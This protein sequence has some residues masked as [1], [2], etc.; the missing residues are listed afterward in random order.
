MCLLSRKCFSCQ[1]IDKQTKMDWLSSVLRLCEWRHVKVSHQKAAATPHH[2]HLKPS[3]SMILIIYLWKNSDITS[4][5][6]PAYGPSRFYFCFPP[7]FNF[8]CCERRG[9]NTGPGSDS[10][11]QEQFGS[12]SAFP[13]RESNRVFIGP[14]STSVVNYLGPN[15]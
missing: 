2:T 5:A 9:E 4:T 8:F 13:P 12:H 6:C 10:H 1:Q 7:V 11:S 14:L 3:S 15:E